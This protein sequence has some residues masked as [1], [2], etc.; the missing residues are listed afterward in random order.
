MN[1]W[2]VSAE[3]LDDATCLSWE[4]S[5]SGVH[6]PADETNIFNW[7]P[8]LQGFGSALTQ[9]VPQTDSEGNTLSL[10]VCPGSPAFGPRASH[11][12]EAGH[13]QLLRS[14]RPADDPD[15]AELQLRLQGGFHGEDPG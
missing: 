10:S 9:R 4:V 2:E 6:Y 7:F 3:F 14:G 15:G 12:G 8:L 13:G 1:L 11:G 5:H